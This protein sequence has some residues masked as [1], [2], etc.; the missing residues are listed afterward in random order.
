MTSDLRQYL[1]CA[2]TTPLAPEVQAE[3]QR[4]DR[5]AWANPSSLHAFGLAAAEQL[6]RSRQQ[7]AAQLGC[8]GDLI[9]TSGGSESIHLALLGAA[10]ELWDGQGSA[11]R[12]LLSAVEHPA[13]EAAA[14]QL[15]RKGWQLERIPV[16]RQGFIDLAVLES[17]LAPPT[18]LVSLIWGQSEV[19]TLQPMDLVGRLC[20]QAGVLLHVDAVQ[21]A[22]QRPIDF[23]ALPIDLLS[24][25]SHKLSGPRGVG[26]LLI[27][28]QVPVR[29]IQSGG[30]QEQ[31]IRAGTEP[32]PLIAGFAKALE[33]LNIQRFQ[34]TKDP[35]I[36]RRDAL[37]TGLLQLPGVELTGPDPL[38]D[39]EQRLSNHI[40][41][42]VA[43]P[44]GVPLSGRSVV[45]AMSRLGYGISSG[46]ACSSSKAAGSPILEAMG[47]APERSSSGL[48]LSLGS[49]HR[50]ADLAPVPIALRE[51]IAA[52]MA[53]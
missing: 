1:D 29:P 26:A 34:G 40:S 18:R 37:L 10:A 43:S 39:P 36:E 7:I 13:T 30:G 16:D 3:I 24:V 41:L 42:L 5:E 4:V 33:L 11:P 52:V 19:G 23:D 27:R 12:L 51:A 31:G 47:I 45:R 20:R 9:F 14:L 53:D 46:S 8:G 15:Q 28:D 48:R 17:Q 35:L 50:D 49:W 2:A 25:A 44:Q 22:A 32:V 38:Q 21:V 6:E